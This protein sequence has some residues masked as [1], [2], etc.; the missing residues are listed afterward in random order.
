MHAILKSNHKVEKINTA[1]ETK[2]VPSFVKRKIAISTSE[3]IEILN[4]EDIIFCEARSNYCL[5]HCRDGRKVL[6]SKTLKCVEEGMQSRYFMRVHQSYLLCLNDI[7]RI[8]TDHVTLENGSKVPVSRA[9][10]PGLLENLKRI[11]NHI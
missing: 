8:L 1:V 6:V 7:S 3:G 2:L 10:R 5:I 9:K 4:I 11:V